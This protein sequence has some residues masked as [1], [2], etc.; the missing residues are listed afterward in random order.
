M[1]LSFISG[2]ANSM[3][4]AKFA[5]PIRI[6]QNAYLLSGISLQSWP[7]FFANELLRPSFK[8][9]WLSTPPNLARRSSIG[10]SFLP[11]PST[12]QVIS[13][14]SATKKQVTTRSL[15]A[16]E[17][18]M[19]P[20]RTQSWRSM[21][22]S[23]AQ[24]CPLWRYTPPYHPINNQRYFCCRPP[25]NLYA[26]LCPTHQALAVGLSALDQRW[27]S[28]PSTL[29]EHLSSNRFSWHKAQIIMNVSPRSGQISTPPWTRRPSVRWSL[30]SRT[31]ATQ[32]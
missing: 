32:F 18:S 5:H 30:I 20:R 31:I 21:A 29:L 15:S 17:T 28:I 27:P 6:Y 2:C 19:S 25:L 22:R 4:D 9:S 23:G 24:T 12:P 16:S 26:V 10:T 3:K 7:L 8:P 14:L 1:I 11:R 13:R